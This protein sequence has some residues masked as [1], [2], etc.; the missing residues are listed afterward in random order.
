MIAFSGGVDSTFLLYAALR[1]LGEK[2]VA[3]TATSPTYPKSER[4]EAE[5]IARDFQVPHRFVEFS[6]SNLLAQGIFRLRGIQT[7]FPSEENSLC[8]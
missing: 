4:D 6:G 1:A 3:V 2:T 5:K 7:V 8:Q